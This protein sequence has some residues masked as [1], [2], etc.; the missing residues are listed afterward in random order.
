MFIV[1]HALTIPLRK[2]RITNFYKKRILEKFDKL[3]EETIDAIQ[4]EI[5]PKKDVFKVYTFL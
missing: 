5:Y 2:C 4:R 1:Y 3:Q